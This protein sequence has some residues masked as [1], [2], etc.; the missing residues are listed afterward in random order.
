[1]TVSAIRL[2]E[3]TEPSTPPTGRVYFYYDEA[4]SLFKYKDDA[5]TVSL[6]NSGITSL[7]A[8]T[9]AAQT[10][11]IGS[12]GTD[13]NIASSGSTHTFH[14]P[15]ASETA[16][17]LITTGS[18][19]IAGDKTFS[20]AIAASNLSG[21]NTGNQ[22]V[23]STISVA[24]QSDI[25]ADSTSD[26]LT[27]AAGAN[28]AITTDASTD[29]ATFAVACG[30]SSGQIQYNNSGAFGGASALVYATSGAHLTATA[31][32]ATDMAI[33]VKNNASQTANIFEA[34]TSAGG[35]YFY[36]GPSTLAGDSAAKNF[37]S[38][39]RT[40]PSSVTAEVRATS[41]SI[42]G[43]GTDDFAQSA[44]FLQLG[45]GY[46]GNSQTYGLQLV[47]NTAGTAGTYASTGGASV[48]YSPV[49]AAFGM[50]SRANGAGSGINLAVSGAAYNSTGTNYGGWFTATVSGA[51][52][53]VGC[54]SFALSATTN[55]AGYFGLQALGSSAPT[56]TNTAL[57]A[58]NGSSTGDIL[59][60]RDDASIVTKVYDGGGILHT[61]VAG[62]GTQ[63]PLLL[64]TAINHTA[65]TAS[66]E[67]TDINFNLAR[68]V[69][70]AT[71]AITTQRAM[72]VQAPTYSFVGAST[73]TNAATLSISG[74]PVAGTNAT[75]TNTAALVVES[76]NVGIGTGSPV[77]NLQ[78]TGNALSALTGTV[79]T[80]SG[81]A[82]VTGSGTLFV[83]ELNAGDAIKIGS[84][85]YTVSSITNNTSLVIT[86]NASA[87]TSGV[88]GYRDTNLIDLQTA[89]G[90]SAVKVDRSGILTTVQGI[91][92]NSASTSRKTSIYGSIW[93]Q[94]DSR[95]YIASSGRQ[96]MDIGYRGGMDGILLGDGSYG[97]AIWMGGV[98]TSFPMIKRNA[99]A[100]NFRLADDSADAAI[101]GGAASF[102][103]NVGIGTTSPGA[104]LQINIP[105]AGTIGQIIRGSAS[106][107]AN[108]L[109]AQTSA[110]ATYFYVGPSTLAGDS[111]N[112]NFLYV[113]R[114]MP[115]T[116]TAEA[117][118]VNCSITGAG[119]SS[120]SQSAM[121]LQLG[122]GYTGSSATFGLKLVNATAGTAASYAG[123][124]SFPYSPVDASVGV[125]SRANGSGSGINVAIVG[126]AY[127]S[128]GTNYGGWF[129]AGTNTATLN[130]G[131]ASF[132]LN[133]TTNCAG[134]FGLQVLG[135]S[136]PT[137]TNTALIASNG[138][139]TGDILE[140][141][142][143]TTIVTKVYDGGGIL[144]T[145]V[146]GTGTQ[147]P[148]LLCTG[149]NHTALTAS[150]EYTDINFNLARTLQFATGAITNQRAIR[151]QAPTYGFVGSSTITDAAT[152]SISGPP[153]AGT[154]ATL[155]NKWALWLETGGV[156][157][158][159]TITT[160]GT[161]GNQTI[162]KPAGRVNIAAAGTTV[163]VTNN[164]VTANSI[165]WA[166]AATNDTTARV[167]SV[168]PGAG[169]FVIN[170]VATTAE[171]AFNWMVIS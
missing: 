33:V 109:E 75:I 119:S 7:N 95:V 103:G 127:N 147:I 104:L 144:H 32:T 90:N 99:A 131:C 41:F 164:L 5:G 3:S 29:T 56:F 37:L 14:I 120:F 100:I 81:S 160:V 94:S 35:S 125:R 80:T 155:T 161:T 156:K 10:L 40:L 137:F 24:T 68:T 122:A 165:V 42:T 15:D 143:D 73:I 128:T 23:F 16:R 130:V 151:I 149:I 168:V 92:F 142:D 158:D 118:A 30:G 162:D 140:L 167:T 79:S 145:Q 84:N 150:T 12:T 6:F 43:A 134:Y 39:T 70:F 157:V 65:L 22:N 115:S 139:S 52:L 49:R 106:Q 53:N 74:A 102:S 91:T 152:V 62:T 117:Y 86:V 46:T 88:T 9:T 85:I 18:Q 133:A 17:G 60:L 59:E 34:Q 38:V 25:V 67:Y 57:I 148:L 107:T 8:L 78:I 97:P 171:T 27:M 169:S 146:A 13:F 123:S 4:D 153:V 126:T 1:M 83:T 114:T 11:A 63:L 138:S 124:A 19:T 47:N 112:K 98:T 113:N 71:G 96:Q 64:L 66:T 44:M 50:R 69:Q 45:S 20:G 121:F 89:A 51:T 129:S 159:T 72:R 61:Q 28:V 93:G 116:M 76:G 2:R 141:R 87:T 82:T 105:A 110:G 135:S 111:V 170:T 48:P 132:A 154:N 101:T 21:T 36:V 55:C 77:S 26:T 136:A 108:V 166:V 58:S 163:T 31:A 54:A